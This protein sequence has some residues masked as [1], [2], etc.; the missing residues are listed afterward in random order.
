M[1]SKYGEAVRQLLEDELKCPD[2]G[3]ENTVGD[4]GTHIEV[5]PDG[6]A[7]CRCC[8]NDWRPKVDTT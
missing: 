3:A 7:I 4:G 5:Q 2:C 1:A 8:L 6:L